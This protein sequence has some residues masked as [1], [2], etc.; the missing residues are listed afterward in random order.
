M[1]FLETLM[2]PTYHNDFVQF[3][4]RWIYSSK[5]QCF[6]CL[7][8]Q[9]CLDR[10]AH[11]RSGGKGRA[12]KMDITFQEPEVYFS[13]LY[14]TLLYFATLYLPHWR[15]FSLEISQRIWELA[16]STN[17]TKQIAFKETIKKPVY[18]KRICL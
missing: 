18:F 7:F 11:D 8:I 17:L 14:K 1:Q 5:Q 10:T 15:F 9:L 4:A 12:E 2:H 3:N 16:I 13:G 6:P